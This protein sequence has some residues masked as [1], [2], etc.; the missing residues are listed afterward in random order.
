MPTGEDD[1]YPGLIPAGGSVN[2]IA[3]PSVLAVYNW[4][5]DPDSYR[6]RFAML[7]DGGD[8]PGC[9]S[10]LLTVPERFDVHL[11]PAIVQ[12]IAKR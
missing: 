5:R 7:A 12:S 2:T 10:M 11:V 8:E 1:D 3:I 9:V 4:P 6:R